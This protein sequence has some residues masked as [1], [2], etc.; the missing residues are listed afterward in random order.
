MI[1]YTVWSEAGGP[2]KTTFAVT[3]AKAHVRHG[4]RVLAVDVDPQNGCLSHYLGVDEDRA[5]GE[6]DNIARHLVDRPRG[7]FADLVRET[8]EG[9]DVIPS[10]NMLEELAGHLDTAEEFADNMGEQFRKEARL[11]EVLLEAGVIEDYDVLVVDPPATLGQH[12]YNAVYATSNLLIPVRYS[13]KGDQSITGLT[14]SVAG[15]EET[16]SDVEVGILGVVP[17]G[18]KDTRNQR[19]YRSRIEEHGL[20]L[21]PVSIREREAMFD[22]AWAAR[23]SAYT[24]VAEHRD[25]LRDRELETL[26]KFDALARSV[27]GEFGVTLTPAD[28]VDDSL[29]LPALDRDPTAEPEVQA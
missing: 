22:G 24:F 21:A 11:R 14:Q 7:P 23:C 12:V 20:P 10:H 3:L 28:V 8:P 15:L 17:N 18:V 25:R 4:Q 16:L 2:G 6:A 26:A 27:S 29:D 19:Q 9:I 13:P 5:D 1:S